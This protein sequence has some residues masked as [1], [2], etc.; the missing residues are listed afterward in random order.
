MTG[1]AKLDHLQRRS[2]I[3]QS[4]R[5]DIAAS[6]DFGIWTF[7]EQ[8]LGQSSLVIRTL[9]NQ[10]IH[11]LEN[12]KKSCDKIKC[13]CSLKIQAAQ[14]QYTCGHCHYSNGREHNPPRGVPPLYKL[15]R[16]VPP[17]RVFVRRFGLKTGT[18]FAH[19]GSGIGYGFRGNYGSHERIYR[20]NF[21]WEICDFD[22]N[23]NNIFYLNTVGFKANIAYGAV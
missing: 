9:G 1:L 7:L 2:R 19:F 5:T 14:P 16:Y 4:D 8:C 22:N 10:W 20:F 11:C 12:K 21:K 3:F 23:N 17:H 6:T 18:N 15:Y 13:L